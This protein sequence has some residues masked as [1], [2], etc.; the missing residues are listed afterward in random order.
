MTVPGILL[1]LVIADR[2]A[3]KG[4]SYAFPIDLQ[5]LS[6]CTL[7]H[8]LRAMA[9]VGSLRAWSLRTVSEYGQPPSSHEA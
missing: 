8:L 3:T 5:R 4:L 2:M 9:A 6:H 7:C 1:P